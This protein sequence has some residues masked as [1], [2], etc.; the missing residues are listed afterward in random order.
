MINLGHY[1]YMCSSSWAQCSDMSHRSCSVAQNLINSCLKPI[2]FLIHTLKPT[3]ALAVV[4]P[5]YEILKSQHIHSSCY[6]SRFRIPYSHWDGLATHVANAQT[7]PFW[8]LDWDTK[9]RNTFHWELKEYAHIVRLN[10]LSLRSRRLLRGTVGVHGRDI[11]PAGS[12]PHPPIQNAWP[13]FQLFTF[14]ETD[15][16]PHWVQFR[17]ELAEDV[18]TVSL[19]RQIVSCTRHIG[20]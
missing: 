8:S 9:C 12:C 2:L 20:I 6:K 18:W 3:E 14:M 7:Q 17:C 11:H 4:P 16:S 19:L 1:T 13:I 15:Q 10:G 5:W